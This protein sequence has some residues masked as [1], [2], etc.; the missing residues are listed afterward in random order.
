M[1]EGVLFTPL[2]RIATPSGDV[3]HGLKASAAGYTG[4][5]EAYFSQ[6]HQGA[7]KSWRLHTLATLNL[8]VPV[9]S[10]RF[11]VYDDRAGS[12]TTGAFEEYVVGH[13][14]YGRLTIWPGIWMAF[15][16]LGPGTSTIL[17]IIDRE[18]DPAESSTREVETIPYAW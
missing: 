1:I 13:A 17:S 6:I 4:F 9:G 10:V 14:N 8:V 16:G 15:Q 7:L 18:H 12:P 5:A 11:V 2:R 3:L